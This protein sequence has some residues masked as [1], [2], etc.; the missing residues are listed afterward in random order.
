MGPLNDAS[1]FQIDEKNN[2]NRKKLKN[3]QKT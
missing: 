2:K 1:M 3:P